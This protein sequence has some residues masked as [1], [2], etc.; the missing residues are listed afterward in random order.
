MNVQQG[1]LGVHRMVQ[2]VLEADVGVVMQH[3]LQDLIYCCMVPLICTVRPRTI[4]S[5]REVSDVVE[6]THALEVS[7]YELSSVITLDLVRS[8]EGHALY[9]LLDDGL[10]DGLC[11]LV[12]DFHSYNISTVFIND[13]ED[14]PCLLLRDLEE[15]KVYTDR[16]AN[17]CCRRSGY[18]RY[19]FEPCVFVASFTFVVDLIQ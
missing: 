2:R 13:V 3:F 8:S 9:P 15:L 4:S 10:D 11:C 5:G 19:V 6:L 17:I 18:L 14:D 7:I 1:V 16:V 12:W